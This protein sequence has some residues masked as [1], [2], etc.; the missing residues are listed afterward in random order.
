MDNN[1]IP[2]FSTTVMIGLNGVYVFFSNVPYMQL[3][4]YF[5]STLLKWQDVQFISD[6]FQL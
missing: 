4:Q 3:R 1:L 6:I 2:M 5:L